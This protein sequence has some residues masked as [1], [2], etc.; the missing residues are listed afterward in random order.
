MGTL[1]S[2]PSG[3]K[4][5]K[6]EVHTPAK[7]GRYPAVLVVY[8][9]DGLSDDHGFGS[10]IRG[11]AAKLAGEGFVALIPDYF[12]STGTSPGVDTVWPALNASQDTWADT[13]ADAAAFADARADVKPSKLGIVGFSLGG[14]LALRV[15]K[16]P[17]AKS[18]ALAVVDFCANL[19]GQRHR[20][21]R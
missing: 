6:V 19:P 14:N 18:K 4:S 10:A 17:S 12:E 5:I 11:F 20:P 13:L 15:A 8:G 21:G 1:E 7:P 16:L 9:T 3:T 2:F